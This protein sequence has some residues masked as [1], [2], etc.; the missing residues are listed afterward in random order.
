M[1]KSHIKQAVQD[2]RAKIRGADAIFFASPEYNYGVSSPLKNALDW[3]SR[4]ANG[5]AIKG[6]WYVSAGQRGD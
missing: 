3:A 5:S 2:F 4:S 6:K 1:A